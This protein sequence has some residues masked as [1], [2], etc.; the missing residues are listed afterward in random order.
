MYATQSNELFSISPVSYKAM[1]YST[2]TTAELKTYNSN[3]INGCEVASCN[4]YYSYVLELHTQ[5][6]HWAISGWFLHRLQH[7]LDNC[8]TLW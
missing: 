4:C 1:I 5:G 8:S 2:N 3:E 6:S 7:H